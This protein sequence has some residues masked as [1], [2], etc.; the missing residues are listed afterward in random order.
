MEV[1]NG[2]SAME[3]NFKFYGVGTKRCDIVKKGESIPVTGR[4]G[5]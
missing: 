4:G 2:G 3:N 5:A 1:T